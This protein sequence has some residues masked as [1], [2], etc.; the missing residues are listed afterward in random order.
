MSVCLS[1][2]SENIVEARAE[3]IRKGFYTLMRDYDFIESITLGTNQ[4]NRVRQ[5]F[6]IAKNMLD[7]AINA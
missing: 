4:V 7:G 1:K 3:S 5:R 2:Y 6:E